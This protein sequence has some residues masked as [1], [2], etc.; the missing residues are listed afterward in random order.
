MD[1]WLVQWEEFLVTI[2]MHMLKPLRVL[3]GL[4]IAWAKPDR[5]VFT[6][7]GFFAG[8]AAWALLQLDVRDGY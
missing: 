5:N 3:V 2:D 8:F 7:H 4:G 6:F 1:S